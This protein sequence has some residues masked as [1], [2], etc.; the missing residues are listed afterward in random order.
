VAQATPHFDRL[1]HGLQNA[2]S[3]LL[4]N[5]FKRWNDRLQAS[6]RWLLGGV[7]LVIL[8]LWNWPL[9]LSL[10]LGL[11]ILVWVYLARQG[12]W[13]LPQTWNWQK[14]W[15]PSQRS[16]TLA[17]F[18]GVMATVG[19]YLAIAI[20]LDSEHPWVATGMILQI[21]MTLA[22]LLLLV[23]QQIQRRLEVGD[24]EGNRQADLLTQLADADPLKR[25][26]AI[27]QLT[28]QVQVANHRLLPMQS[29]DLIDCFRLMLNRETE[30]AL[31][32]ALLDGIRVLNRVPSLEASKTQ[33][34]MPQT[35]P[36]VRQHSRIEREG[37]TAD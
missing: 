33:A 16:L 13:K 31:C 6:W 28:Q 14:L 10:G 24:R 23:W 34:I 2:S 30:P 7:A 21:G 27:R 15:L 35:V 11:A 4:S 25:L 9:I 1:I 3:V 20:W 17:I 26:I 37:R 12:W 5:R 19:S 8:L 18:S 36:T 22:V 29:S 32:S